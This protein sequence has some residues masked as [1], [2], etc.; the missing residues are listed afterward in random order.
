MVSTLYDQ[1]VNVIKHKIEKLAKKAE[2]KKIPTLRISK[3]E[4][5][6]AKASFI[7]KKITVGTKLLSQWQKGEIDENDVEV[8]LAHEIGHLMDF[9][10]KFH[11]VFVKYNALT[12]AYLILGVVLPKLGSDLPAAEPWIPP[13]L[14]F[15]IWAIFLPWILRRAAFAV[16]LKADKN[17]SLLIKDQLLANSIVKRSVF[18]PLQGFGPIETWELLLRV[19]L[20]PS[21]SERLRNLNFEIKERKIEIQKIEN[22]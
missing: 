19:I 16:Q 13:L 11:S 22:R 4:H 18:T 2:F 12:L 14:F 1:Q 9:E 3:D 7:R 20:Y 5:L 6:V 21:L 15:I 8:T 10:R 17:A